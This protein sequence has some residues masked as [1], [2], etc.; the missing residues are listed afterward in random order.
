MK[1]NAL[2]CGCM[3]GEFGWS[4]LRFA[5]YVLGTYRRKYNQKVKLIVCT[6]EDRFDLY[7]QNADIL[8]PLKIEG[9]G[10]KYKA[11]CFR[12]INYPIEEYYKLNKVLYEKYSQQFNIVEHI[13]PDIKG[14]IFA[15]KDQYDYN[16]MLFDFK[17]RI[18]NKELLD[19]YIKSKKKSIVIA[20]RYREGMRRNWKNWQE[21]YDR[22]YDSSLPDIF[23]FIVCGKEGEYIPDS[24]NRVYDI[25]RIEQNTNT[26]LVGITIE[27]IKRS[28][29]TVGSQSGI[30]NLSLL[31]K[32]PVLEWGHQKHLHTITYNPK[33]TKI[34]FL[35]DQDY[36]LSAESIFN[37][38]K[39]LLHY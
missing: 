21:L 19:N 10:T 14:K 15:K 37:E 8:V 3:I 11:D 32:T 9:D 12:L 38:M 26:S 35:T 16:Q 5:P 17:P 4:I 22:I 28:I 36:T 27:A 31:L 34:T 1:E 33:N 30:P 18:E 13:Y 25:N 39:K 29:L 20:P 7:G 24:K 2:L 6:R 23:D